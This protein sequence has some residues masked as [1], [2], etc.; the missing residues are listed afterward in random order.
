MDLVERAEEHRNKL[1]S[2][3]FRG[4]D[5]RGDATAV[6]NGPKINL[7]EVDAYLIGQALASLYTEKG[8]IPRVLVTAD[9]RPSSPA[10]QQ[11]LALGLAAAGAQVWVASEPTPTGATSWYILEKTRELD[12]AI[13]ITGSH[14]PYYNNG[15]KITAKQNDR[16]EPDVS[17]L[18]QALYGERLKALYYRIVQ[19]QITQYPTIPGNVQTISNVVSDYQKNM[20]KYFRRLLQARGGKFQQPFRMVL[21]AGN[22]LGCKAIPIF[23]D[24]GVEM[25]ELFTDLEGTF[26]N[27]PADPSKPDGV[28]AAQEKVKALNQEPSPHPWFATVFDG[29]G[30]R[31]GVIDEKGQGIYPERI[32]VI[33]YTRFLLANQEGLRILS[34][35][36]QNIGLAL[37]VRGT[38]VVCDVIEYFGRLQALRHY[39]LQHKISAIEVDQAVASVLAKMWKEPVLTP[40]MFPAHFPNVPEAEWKRI[41]A[42]QLNYGVVGKYIP[43]GYP[44]HRAYVREQIQKL[45]RLKK[46]LSHEEQAA[47]TQMQ[48]QYTSAESSGHFFYGTCA[49]MPEV[50]VDDGIYSILVLLNLIDTLPNFEIK[51][52]LMPPGTQP[53]LSNLFGSVAW[54]PVSNEIRDA[55]PSENTQ[56]F[57]IVSSITQMI[58]A[59]KEAPTGKFKQ[60]IR[61]IIDVDGVRAEFVD[62]SF[63]LV[64]A[65]N[66]SPML[67]YKFEATTTQRLGEVIEEMIQLM[68]PFQSQGVSTLELEQERALYH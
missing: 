37:D 13:Q 38:A 43:A 50:M 44:N 62:G 6:P 64:R 23:R 53:T 22:G 31:S 68:K 47:L 19:K 36:N 8:Q 30:D 3:I 14:N 57:A 49:S 63:A 2:N 18:P 32:L 66:T 10:L 29:D 61:S 58:K 40:A 5:I 56:K 42:E 21:D 12:V 59:E 4:Y 65:S 25:I 34:R 45:E 52:G 24:L 35:L 27:H 20:A 39:Y 26:P 7:S 16:G 15:F 46:H 51:Y 9:H 67:T 55:A 1:D 33:Y 54:R 48:R 11:G 60:A 17:G 28:F 41:L